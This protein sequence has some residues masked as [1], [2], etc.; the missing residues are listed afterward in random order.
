MPQNNLNVQHSAKPE[1]K[2]G[3]IKVIK[4]LREEMLLVELSQYI[5]LCASVRKCQ[6]AYYREQNKATKQTLLIQCKQLE[7]KQER[8]GNRLWLEYKLYTDPRSK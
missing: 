4:S 2:A 3:L 1:Y 6:K 7:A 8:E 5:L